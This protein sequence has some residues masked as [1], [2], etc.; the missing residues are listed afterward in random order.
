[1][2]EKLEESPPYINLSIFSHFHQSSMIFNMAKVIPWSCFDN[3]RVRC[4]RNQFIVS[5]PSVMHKY[6]SLCLKRSFKG[7]Q[8]SFP[9]TSRDFVWFVLPVI[10]PANLWRIDYYIV[11]TIVPY[12]SYLFIRN[13]KVTVDKSPNNF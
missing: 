11:K 9:K 1:M 2:T 5:N 6:R 4:T 8:C 3:R 13:F 12:T 7:C 10:T